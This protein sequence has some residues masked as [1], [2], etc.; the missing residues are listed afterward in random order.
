MMERKE[1]KI[2]EKSSRQ[3]KVEEKKKIR[4][5]WKKTGKCSKRKKRGG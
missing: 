1:V 3:T 2:R 4:T 5:G